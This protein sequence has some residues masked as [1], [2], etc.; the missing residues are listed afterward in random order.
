MTEKWIPHAGDNNTAALEFN[1][2]YKQTYFNLLL[3][4]APIST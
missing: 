2:M 4:F 1:K 3:D